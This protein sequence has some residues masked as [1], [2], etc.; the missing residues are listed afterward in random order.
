[1]KEKNA[2]EEEAL[3]DSE[4]VRKAIKA[5]VSK[6]GPNVSKE[7]KIEQ[8]KVLAKIFEQGMSPKEAMDISD[9]DIANLY[10][11][12]FYYFE[13]GKFRDACELFKFLCILDPM[14]SEF[15][16][17][18]GTCY[19]RMKEYDNAI[20]SYMQSAFINPRDPVP[21]FYCFDCYLNL[22]DPVSAGIMLCNVIA[23]AGDDPKYAKIKEKASL[24]MPAIEKEVMALDKVKHQSWRD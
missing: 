5:T 7:E 13:T 21:L 16:T 19:H 6:M 14:E 22:K 8:A 10:Q 4:T 15:S 3:I 12:S 20:R 2:V 17:A 11:A 24:M 1:M 23:R 9:E 18:L